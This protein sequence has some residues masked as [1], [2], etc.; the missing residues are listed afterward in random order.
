MQ[1]RTAKRTVDTSPI[2]TARHGGVPRGCVYCEYN[3]KQTCWQ[4]P[5]QRMWRAKQRNAKECACLLRRR[6]IHP[7]IG[8]HAKRGQTWLHSILKAIVVNCWNAGMFG[9]EAAQMFQFLVGHS[10]FSRNSCRAPQTCR[11][12][13]CSDLTFS[14]LHSAPQLTSFCDFSTVMG[15]WE[16]LRQLGP[17]SPSRG[18]CSIELQRRCNSNKANQPVHQGQVQPQPL[19][20]SQPQVTEQTLQVW[21]ALPAEIRHDPSMASFQMENERIHGE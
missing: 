3:A 5:S 2:N 21:R 14:N 4:K 18:R 20:E 6:Q 16:T 11:R 17:G 19:P 9:N 10:R 1:P 15:L 12:F 13:K 8:K 7:G